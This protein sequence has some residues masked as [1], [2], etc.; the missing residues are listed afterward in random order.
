MF[1]FKLDELSYSFEL[2]VTAEDETFYRLNTNRD[3]GVYISRQWMTF[4][5]FGD[6]PHTIFEHQFATWL[7]QYMEHN[8]RR[9]TLQLVNRDPETYAVCIGDTWVK[10]KY[11][12]T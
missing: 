12:P 3:L 9:V 6:T 4:T 10:P 1:K 8:P 11:H 7:E 5:I 2:P